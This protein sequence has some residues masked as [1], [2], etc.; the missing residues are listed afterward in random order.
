MTNLPK[1]AVLGLGAMGHAFAGNLL[2]KGFVVQAWNRSPEKGRDLVASG[3]TLCATPRQAVAHVDVIISMLAD[4]KVTLEVLEEI[5]PVC[6]KEAI[7]CQM[8]TIGVQQ[9]TDSIQ[10]LKN[11]HPAMIFVE[12]PVSGT[13]GPAENAQILVLASGEREKCAAA[14]AVF[15]AIARGTQWFGEAGNGQKIKL[16]LNSWLISMMQ[17]V[18]ESNMLAARLGFTSVQFWDAIA[19]GPLA[20]PYVQAKLAAI[21]K[22]DYAPQMQLVHALKDAKLALELSDPGTMPVLHTIADVWGNAVE[23]GFGEKDLSSIAMWM[24]VS[25]QREPY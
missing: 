16:V 3:L 19:G 11:L 9:T 6:K 5:A 12:A 24:S 18:V 15:S 10:L 22:N 7:F 23:D 4:G 1:V 17:G 14:E 8:G 25:V 21:E 2:Q 13:K 20:A